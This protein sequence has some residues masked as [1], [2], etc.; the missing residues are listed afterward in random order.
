[1][2]DRPRLPY[3]DLKNW[4]GLYTKSS[5]DVLAPEQL[6]VAS[7]VDFFNIYGAT[8]KLKGSSRV[9]SAPYTEA[10][11]AKPIS[12][13]GFYKASDL[14]GAILRHVM[15]ASG[16]YI[17]KLNGTALDDIPNTSAGTA[18]TSGRVSGLFHTYDQLDR[19]LYMTNYDP[20]II[21]RGDQMLK[22]D[23]AR[24]S[25]WGLKPPGSQEE[26]KEDF[27]SAG[28]WTTGISNCT[29]T[30]DTTVSYD[31]AAVQINQTA[32]TTLCSIQK[33][34]TAFDV[35]RDT[36][37]V[38]L[39]GGASQERVAFWLY[40]PRGQLDNAFTATPDTSSGLARCFSVYLGT[41]ASNYWRFDYQKGDLNEG[42][43][44]IKIDIA[45]AIANGGP[46]HY[47]Q[48][49]FNSYEDGPFGRKLGTFN[50]DPAGTNS[51]VT[52]LKF[53]FQS[54]TG[55]IFEGI[56]LD[57]FVV[58]D[59]GA[60]TV[61]A[62]GNGLFTGTYQWRTSF[63]NK[64]GFESNTG[65]K[66]TELTAQ[67]HGTFYL[68][69]IPVAVDKQV[70][71]RRLYRTVA[72]GTIFL[73]LTELPN[74][75]E[76]SFQDE[77]PDGSLSE[78]TAPQAGDFSSD[79]SEPPH[80]GIFK[81]WKRTGFMAGDAQSPNTLYF[82]EDDS[83]E[84]WPLINTFELDDKITG[85]YETY[86]GIVVETE[87]GKWQVIGDNPDFAVDKM[88]ENMGCVGRRACGTA[89]LVGY[90]VDRDGLRLYD[91][92]DTS[93]VSEPIRD[94]YAA[95]DRTN[96]EYVHTAHS[97][98]RNSLIQF[99]PSAA[100]VAPDTPPV[101]DSILH[102]QYAVDDIRTGW[103]SNITPPAELNLI[104]AEEIEDSNG[105]FHIYAGTDD[106]M[107]M[108]IITTTSQNW[109]STAGV[110]SA[111][112]T[113]FQSPYLRLGPLGA[114]SEGVTGKV[115]PTYLEIRQ[116]GDACTW[117][118]TIDMAKGPDQAQPTDTATLTFNFGSNNSLL[119]LPVKFGTAVRS[120]YVRITL[121]NSD[122]SVD[123]SI[124]ALRLYF[125][126]REGQFP[127]TD[128]ENVSGGGGGPN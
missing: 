33:T 12:W 81:I 93:K 3:V 54:A 63:V 124:T 45:S 75:V 112:T 107:I 14:A 116:K 46:I 53:E 16:T 83:L 42:W 82:S 68:N 86:S 31:G 28:T 91:L 110:E 120:E 79:N 9:L 58:F 122:L 8:S 27:S 56:R 29:V 44:F 99:N 98:A 69:F 71:A 77:V 89:K 85:I 23:G 62:L 15:I 95:L 114:E 43:N 70:T 52:F 51:N 76:T 61:L 20:D 6:K 41:N 60:P 10:A 106:G 48:S 108:E 32:A 109:T 35:I 55:T 73:K 18:S 66:S 64:Y 11:V 126:V 50:P 40:I 26:I 111:V 36:R 105:D 102:Y 88:I 119:R 113:T 92:N 13:I 37:T 121:T 39:I 128:L 57:K 38:G 118:A 4:A 34:V 72:G 117:T 47:G 67:L 24:I 115:E 65:P 1:M 5:T 103:W 125:H 25:N 59:Q 96:I 30:D 94:K 17:K 100:D 80:G 49:G 90:A 21:G 74:N 97:K 127:V 87:T 78:V 101:Y 123:S 84:A 104:C 2:P 19:F 22:Y 7:N